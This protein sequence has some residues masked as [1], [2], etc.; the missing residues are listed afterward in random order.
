MKFLSIQILFPAGMFREA[1]SHLAQGDLFE[2]VPKECTAPQK[3]PQVIKCVL[4]VTLIMG[5]V[6]QGPQADVSV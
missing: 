5:K 1:V 2:L 6:A 4:S 3:P